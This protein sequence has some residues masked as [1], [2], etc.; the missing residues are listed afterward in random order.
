MQRSKVKMSMWNWN[1]I[2]KSTHDFFER[3]ES[4]NMETNNSKDKLKTNNK[5]VDPNPTIPK[6]TLN[7][8]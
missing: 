3:W 6:I 7:G 2:L 8:L 5:M 4:K 1:E